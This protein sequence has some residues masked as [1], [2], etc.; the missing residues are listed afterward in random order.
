MSMAPASMALPVAGMPANSPS[1]VPRNVMLAATRSPSTT[2]SLIS[3]DM[4]GNAW[5]I[6][7]NPSMAPFLSGAVPGAGSWSTKSSD[8]ISSARPRSCF[9]STSS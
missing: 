7:R 1:F 8:M 4:S 3:A 2:M 9:P 6:M 5:N